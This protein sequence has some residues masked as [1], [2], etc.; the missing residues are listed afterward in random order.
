MSGLA[1]RLVV[2]GLL[3]AGFGVQHSILATL[4]VKARATKRWHIQ[5]IEWRT[6]ESIVNVLYVLVASALWQSTSTVIWTASGLLRS[7]LWVAVG[8]SWLWY[9]EL[10]LVEY[11][12]G[13]AFGSTSLINR[14]ERR[15]APNLVPWK[16][17]SRRWIRFPVHTAFFG[18][19]LLLPTMTADLLVLGI[20]ANVYNVIG[21]ILYDRR[22]LRVAGTSYKTYVDVTGLIWPPVYRAPRGA[23]ALPMP[24]PM[25]WNAPVR[26]VPGVL[27]GIVA[28]FFY[29]S[30]LGHAAHSVTD[31]V[32]AA[33]AALIVSAVGGVLLGLIDQWGLF[34]RSL[35]DWNDRQTVLSTTD[36][37]MAAVGVVTWISISVL[38]GHGAPNFGLYLPMWF[39]VQ[40]SG[41]VAAY[42]GIRLAGFGSASSHDLS[43]AEQPL[44]E[45]GV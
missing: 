20:V 33:A 28:G 42:F 23:G 2:D 21:S 29:W 12:A 35:S 4:R 38:R 41:H 17:G 39:I 22:L 11:D 8:A 43:T 31:S 16:V 9:W 37:A 14:L 3:T 44:A 36:A 15:I 27:L 45:A 10:H 6:V 26:H 32:K 40:Y 25:H 1:V 19:F 34:G 7:L 13:L 18:M 5:S 24:K 30:V